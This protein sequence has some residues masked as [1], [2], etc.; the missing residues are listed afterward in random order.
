MDDSIDDSQ[1]PKFRMCVYGKFGA[2][3]EKVKNL[4][5][6]PS[7]PS[8][9]NIISIYSDSLCSLDEL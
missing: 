7:C 9:L 1:N 6:T 8:T 5:L 2:Y 3:Y 4:N